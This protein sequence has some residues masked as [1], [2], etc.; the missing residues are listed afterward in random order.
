MTIQQTLTI[1]LTDLPPA[2]QG[3]L[4]AGRRIEVVDGTRIVALL[5][6]ILPADMTA[7]EAWT[8]L[9]RLLAEVDASGRG[10]AFRTIMSQ[11]QE[12]S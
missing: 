4:A 6:P 8:G 11:E 5:V 7:A 9:E 1:P 3:V 2:V 10:E 12:R